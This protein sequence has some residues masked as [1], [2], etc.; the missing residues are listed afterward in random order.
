MV[1]GTHN[2]LPDERNK[3]VLIYINGEFFKRE[4]AKI[5]VFDSGSL[6]GDGIWEAMRLHN[7][8]L[9]F[10]DLHLERLWTAAATVCMIIKFI[11]EEFTNEIL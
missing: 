5:S 7:G 4:D 9:V 3:D 6:V 2:A 10:L 1:H 8:V 11:K